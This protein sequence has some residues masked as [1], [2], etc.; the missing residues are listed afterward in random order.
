MTACTERKIPEIERAAEFCGVSYQR[1]RDAYQFSTA[2]SRMTRTLVL[3][4]CE[5]YND[6]GGRVSTRI[7]P[8]PPR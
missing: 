8:R 4:R 1:M 5:I 6:P 3:G 7:L 2:P